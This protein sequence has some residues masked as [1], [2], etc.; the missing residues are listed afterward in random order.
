MVC[1]L[2]KHLTIKMAEGQKSL[3]SQSVENHKSVEQE[4]LEAVLQ[5]AVD[6]VGQYEPLL[7]NYYF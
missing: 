4:E 5:E 7:A 1:T 2:Q 3:K 6:K